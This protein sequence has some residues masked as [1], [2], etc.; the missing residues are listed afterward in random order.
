[1]KKFPNKIIISDIKL[2]NNQLVWISSLLLLIIITG[3]GYFIFKEKPK[4]NN[5]EVSNLKNTINNLY[6]VVNDLKNTVVNLNDKIN[7]LSDN[8]DKRFVYVTKQLAS[9]K[10][11]AGNIIDV[12]D[13]TKLEKI[14]LE[15]NTKVRS[16]SLEV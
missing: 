8:T 15:K 9:N 1:M 14:Q 5:I 13:M 12:I 2:T 11:K 7:K 16:L 4:E 10:D 6:L 3:G